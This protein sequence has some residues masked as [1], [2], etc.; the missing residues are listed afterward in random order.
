M[1]GFCER[2]GKRCP[3]VTTGQEASRADASEPLLTVRLGKDGFE[4]RCPECGHWNPDSDNLIQ[5]IAEKIAKI[6]TKNKDPESVAEQVGK[7][8]LEHN[9][10]ISDERKQKIRSI[11]KDKYSKIRGPQA[12]KREPGKESPGSSFEEDNKIIWNT[13]EG[14]LKL[15]DAEPPV[16]GEAETWEGFRDALQSTR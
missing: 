12:E 6:I 1:Q 7:V 2:C 13:I 11:I 5:E 9:F 4:W 15:F 3:P 8:L 16:W 10:Q 14:I